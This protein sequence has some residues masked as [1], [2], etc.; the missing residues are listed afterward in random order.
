LRLNVELRRNIYR[1]NRSHTIFVAL[2]LIASLLFTQLAVAAYACPMML[3]SVTALASVEQTE[4]VDVMPC[5]QRRDSS[6]A[7][8]TALCKA[9]CTDTERTVGDAFAEPPIAF[10][11]AFIVMMPPLVETPVCPPESAPGLSHTLGPPL[12][13]TH[14]CLRI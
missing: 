7:S 5:H 14:C 4:S 12:A 6:T 8:T 3:R 13:I 9:H 2:L 1:M 10:V 11:A